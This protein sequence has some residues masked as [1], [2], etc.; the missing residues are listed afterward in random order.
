VGESAGGY[1]AGFCAF[2]GNTTKFK[3]KDWENYSSRI[4]CAVLWYPATNHT[5]YN[6]IDYISK[7]DVPLMLIH[8]DKDNLVPIYHS[9]LIEKSCKDNNVSGEM[10]V[11]EGAD[12]GFFDPNGKF[13]V[14]R[15]NMERAVV[16]TIDYFKR[17]LSL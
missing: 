17:Q 12:H 6:M 10:V 16:L 3:T 13:D 7:G 9:Y 5:G 8:G 11:I 1:L 2:A 4:N 14:Y 15:K